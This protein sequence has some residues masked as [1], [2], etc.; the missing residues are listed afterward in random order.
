[1]LKEWSNLVGLP[2][3]TRRCVLG[4]SRSKVGVTSGPHPEVRADFQEGDEDSNFS[5]FRVRRLTE[6]LEPLHWIAFP[7][8]I[9]TKPLI[10][11]IA[12][13]L[14]IEKP[15]FHWKA[16]RR[17]PFPKTVLMKHY[18]VSRNCYGNNLF[19][20]LR[21]KNDVTAPEMNSPKGPGRQRLRYRDHSN[22]CKN[23]AP[24]NNS[25]TTPVMQSF[26]S[27]NCQ[28][29]CCNV[30]ALGLMVIKRVL[31]KVP[32]MRWQCLKHEGLVQSCRPLEAPSWSTLWH[33]EVHAFRVQGKIWSNPCTSSLPCFSTLTQ[34]SS[35]IR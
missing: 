35:K 1:M 11:W 21:C 26:P 24:K 12:S 4:H 34:A 13:P 20:V 25:K 32:R 6:W 15:F 10:H 3:V 23:S 2:L 8:E 7:V 27:N 16:L 31:R 17:I 28:K 5:I 30:I 18:H 33:S 19:A 9:L 29:K 14:F 22:P